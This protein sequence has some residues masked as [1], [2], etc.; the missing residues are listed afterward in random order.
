VVIEVTP[1]KIDFLNTANDSSPNSYI[2]NQEEL[3]TMSNQ[4][5]RIAAA[6][7]LSLRL[8]FTLGMSTDNSNAAPQH[9]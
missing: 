5:P 7:G 1:V 3:Q 9:K 8:N 6:K 4:K 2:L